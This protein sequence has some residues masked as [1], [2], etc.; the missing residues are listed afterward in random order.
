[1]ATPKKQ[2]PQETP[3]FV[4]QK[5]VSLLLDIT[6]R[7]AQELTKRGVLKRYQLPAGAR[8]NLVE[9]VKDYITYLNEVNA[10]RKERDPNADRK[11]MAE[12]DLMEARAAKEKIRLRDTE[13]K[14]HRAEDVHGLT[15]DLLSVIAEKLERLPRKLGPKMAEKITAPEASIEIEREVYRI[16]AELGKYQY[17]PEEAER[18]RLS[19]KAAAKPTYY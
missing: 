17:D 3:G 8:Y 6:P 2:M 11:A 1:M 19:R 15:A 18:R 16:L 7:W 13:Q 9:C 5:D 4:K 10:Q 14:Y 12:A